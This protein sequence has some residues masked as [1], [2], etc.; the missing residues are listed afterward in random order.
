MQVISGSQDGQNP[1][2][3]ESKSSS[4]RQTANFAKKI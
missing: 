3:I 4:N 2:Y 1:E